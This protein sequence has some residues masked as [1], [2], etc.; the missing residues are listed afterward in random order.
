M[1]II[2]AFIHAFILELSR[3]NVAFI[4]T[5]YIFDLLITN[6]AP[7]ILKGTSH[8]WLSQN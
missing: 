1:D 7:L 2:K 3:F 6:S 5:D 8:H 4:G